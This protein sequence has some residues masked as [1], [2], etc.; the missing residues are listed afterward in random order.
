MTS[1][2]PT[3]TRFDQIIEGAH[4]MMFRGRLLTGYPDKSTLGEEY[5]YLDSLTNYELYAYDTRSRHVLCPKCYDKIVNRARFGLC[6]S[7]YNKEDHKK[8]PIADARNNKIYLSRRGDKIV[9]T[10]GI[11]K[12][13]VYEKLKIVSYTLEMQRPYIDIARKDSCTPDFAIK[14]SEGRWLNLHSHGTLPLEYLVA[15]L[16]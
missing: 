4:G 9:I 15:E 6:A 3:T 1:K 16:D 12:V 2:K 8:L 7:C 13:P 10:G 14:I 11:I 5:R